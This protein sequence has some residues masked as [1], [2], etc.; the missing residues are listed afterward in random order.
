M[1]EEGLQHLRT[2]AMWEAYG[3]H[4]YSAMAALL[5]QDDKPQASFTA[6]SV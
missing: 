3:S 5:A 4:M 1:L 2:P 6:C